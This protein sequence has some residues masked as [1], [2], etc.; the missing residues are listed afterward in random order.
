MRSAFLG[1]VS[2]SARA[3]AAWVFEAPLGE[4]RVIG[5]FLRQRMLDA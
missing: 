3:N 4:W 2:A 5:D 1:A